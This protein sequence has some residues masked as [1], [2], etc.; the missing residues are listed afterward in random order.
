[1]SSSSPPITARKRRLGYLTGRYPAISH[2][3]VAREI[4]G[5]RT[6]GWEVESFS[7]WRTEDQHVLS[8][9]DRLER[10]RTFAL[11]PP[12]PTRLFQFA[13]A[14]LRALR[15]PQSYIALLAEALSLGGGGLR[16][17]L[18]AMSW[19]TE[20]V[21]VHDR[22]RARGIE[23]LHVHLGGTAAF[24][25]LLVGRLSRREGSN[26]TWSMTVHGPHEFYAIEKEQLEA[27]TREASLVICIS[28]F[29]RSQLMGICSE[30]T[31]DKLHVVR[32]GV[33]PTSFSRRQETSGNL[34]ANGAGPCRILNVG[35]LDP[36]KGQGVLLEALAELT[37]RGCNA[38]LTVV[39]GGARQPML[40]ELATKFGVDS[41][42]RWM[43]AI[44]Q[45][46]IRDFYEDADIFC[47][48][49]FAEGIP[50][51]LMEA[52]AMGLPV[53]TSRI[54]G[55]PELITNDAEGLLVR[56]ARSD[57]LADAL[58]RLCSSAALRAE[59]GQKGRARVES[60]YQIDRNVE[61]LSD[62][63]EEALS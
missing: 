21:L 40:E 51:V 5:L 47:L 15:R 20:A 35:R 9:H 49:S 11:L 7:I 59:M 33:D 60:D 61:Q 39:G 38:S 25:G 22:C 4:E 46:E 43:G 14:H 54:A 37:R 45:D 28:D 63:F 34:A 17:R 44:G 2:T 8:A 29:A 57:E 27:K 16:R 31:W 42:V 24:V 62:V 12:T 10:D 18:L 56:P 26:V 41:S 52:M 36:L 53:V 19:F 13:R 1:M 3:F 6:L 48:P 30:E 32:C 55:I 23:H 58:E 50:V